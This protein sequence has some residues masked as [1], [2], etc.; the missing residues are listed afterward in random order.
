MQI[1][2]YLAHSLNISQFGW[3]D[4]LWKYKKNFMSRD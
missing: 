2:F 1:H 4:P 3:M